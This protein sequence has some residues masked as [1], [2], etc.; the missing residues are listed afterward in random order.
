MLSVID[1]DISMYD[2]DCG[3][4]PKTANSMKTDLP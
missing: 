4:K 1:L 3:G 2:V